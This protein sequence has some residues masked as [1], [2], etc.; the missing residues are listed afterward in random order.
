[1][2]PKMR[3]PGPSVADVKNACLVSGHAQRYPRTRSLLR[4]GSAMK[5]PTCQH[6]NSVQAKYCEE[7]AASPV[8]AS[9]KRGVQVWSTAKSCAPCSRLLKPV[10]DDPYRDP[11]D[12]QKLC[13]PVLER[14]ELWT[15]RPAA[16]TL[17]L[18][19]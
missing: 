4:P 12:V 13:D 9:T 15:V 19:R 17:D 2:R 7:R 1:V 18:S 5:C 10:A 16:K 8:C 3:M 11:E 14:I 6:E